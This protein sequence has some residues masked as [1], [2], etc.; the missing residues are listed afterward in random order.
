MFTSV[1]V[2]TGAR[3]HFG[4][5]CCSHRSERQFGG[6][7]LMVDSPDCRVTAARSDRDELIAPPEFDEPLERTVARV[8]EGRP[9]RVNVRVESESS[10]PRHA[11]LGSGTQFALAVGQALSVLFA[12]EPADVPSLA[13][14]LN[15]G[16]RSAV[17]IHGFQHGGFLV[18]AGK[19]ADGDVGTLGVQVGVPDDW[20]FV[21]ITPRERRGLAGDSEASAFRNLADMSPQMTAQLCRIALMRLLPAL[22]EADLPAFGAALFEYGRR[23][24]EFFAAVQGGVFADPAM[25][26]LAA[27]LRRAGIA[28]VAQSSWGPTIAVVLAGENAARQ[29]ASDLQTGETAE[30]CEVVVT[31]P[32]N[33]GALV[34]CDENS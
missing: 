6:I 7:G 5:L 28:G 17:G 23:V 16:T 20:R 15:R 21:L 14:R 24:G 19:R 30:D 31:G 8:C 33:R 4:P 22:R 1:T 27:R 12:G 9:S 32:R 2:T 10:I 26:R 25:G 34:H 13:R 18:D 29:L 11:G 3:L